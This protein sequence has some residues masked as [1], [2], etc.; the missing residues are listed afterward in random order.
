MV[1]HARNILESEAI[2]LMLGGVIGNLKGMSPFV[3]SK[4]QK[5]TNMSSIEKLI[6]VEI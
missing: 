4:A 1:E 6:L 5:V 2:I 3:Q